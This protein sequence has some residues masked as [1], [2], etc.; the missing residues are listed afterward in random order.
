[1][2][3]KPFERGRAWIEV[4]L[5]ALAHNLADIRS[6]IPDTCEIM[7][8]VK[9]N[10]YGHGVEEVAR[11]LVCEGIGA[12]AVATVSEG[13]ELRDYV[14]DG[15]I[16]VFGRTH[17]E[18]AKI[19]SDLKLS[20]LVVDGAYA[21]SLS[22]T[23][24]SINVHVAIDTGMH[25]LG[26]ELSN[27]S[28]IESVF[29]YENLNVEGVATHLSSPDGLRESDVK[30]TNAQLERFFAV[31]Q[32]LKDK[33][34]DTGKLHV[35]SSYGIYNYPQMQCDYVRPGIMMYGVKSQNDDT[36]LDTNLRPMLS[37]RAVIAQVRWIEAGECVS[38]GRTYTAQ[39][40]IKIA[41]V[42][43]GYA[44]GIPR[45]LSG[46]GGMCLVNGCKVPVIGRVCMDMLILDVT[47]VPHVEAGDIATLIG[48]DGDE[49]IYCEDAAEAAGTISNDL[50]SGL[51]ARLSR[52]YHQAKGEMR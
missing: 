37:L 10:A 29:G 23:G 48:A 20:Q 49:R 6:K 1:M 18:D 50:L 12:F 13:V 11:R 51:G 22:D 28:E 44:D 17:P 21:K 25:R 8:V 4:D 43:I 24:Y 19:L 27:F 9:A 15:D 31:V 42:S 47:N 36:R 34:Y 26:M 41:T 2:A 33:G 5:D 32:K 52:V 3:D 38:Y 7:A 35:Q 40:P 46:K 39:T 30:F 14:H 16:L 45:H